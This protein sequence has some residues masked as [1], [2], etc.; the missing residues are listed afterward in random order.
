MQ[1]K[2]PR[3]S[4]PS[5]HY[6]MDLT[7]VMLSLNGKKQPAVN[8]SLSEHDNSMPETAHSHSMAS[9]LKCCGAH[10]NPFLILCDDRADSEVQGEQQ[11]ESIDGGAKFN[12][13]S[14]S[15]VK[16]KNTA[17]TEA[18]TS[19]KATTYSFLWSAILVFFVF[20]VLSACKGWGITS[21]SCTVEEAMMGKGFGGIESLNDSSTM[22]AACAEFVT[23][24]QCPSAE[25]LH[26]SICNELGVK[27]ESELGVKVK[28]ER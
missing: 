14:K 4:V 7:L 24:Q 28:S 21:A 8:V 22:A 5:L 6:N 11:L 18:T 27:V 23:L 26:Y 16:V 13:S 25:G 15:G 10:A 12:G 19:T 20:A 2:V 9:D 17:S 1:S 3:P